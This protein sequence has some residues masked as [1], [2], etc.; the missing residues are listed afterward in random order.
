MNRSGVSI[1]LDSLQNLKAAIATAERLGCPSE[2]TR[3]LLRAARLLHG[4][5]A[6]ILTG[7]W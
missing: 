5:R 2:E 3:D 1:D 4:L 6:K 7:D